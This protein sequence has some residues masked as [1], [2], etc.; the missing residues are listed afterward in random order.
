MVVVGSPG[1]NAGFWFGQ[2]ESSNYKVNKVVSGACDSQRV[3]QRW[4]AGVCSEGLLLRRCKHGAVFI[5]WMDTG[6]I[7]SVLRPKKFRTEP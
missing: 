5:V 3:E 4:N 7:K 6:A 1:R 2:Q